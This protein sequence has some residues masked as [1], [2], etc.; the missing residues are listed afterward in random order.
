MTIDEYMT[1]KHRIGLIEDKRL[2]FR[3]KSLANRN[4]FYKHHIK[5]I[6]DGKEWGSLDG[7]IARKILVAKIPR[8][9]DYKVVGFLIY[10]LR[11]DDISLDYWLVDEKCRSQ[12][13]GQQLWNKMVAIGESMSIVN[14]NVWFKNEQRLIDTYTRMGFKYIPKYKGKEQQ[15]LSENNHLNWWLIRCEGYTLY[16]KVVRFLD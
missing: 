10:S 3:I 9:K 12:G 7:T 4:N 2:K 16:D 1:G 5:N 14:I 13:I 8:G 11:W 6:I 15:E